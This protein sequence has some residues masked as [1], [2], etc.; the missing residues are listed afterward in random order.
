M[1]PP[2]NNTVTTVRPDNKVYGTEALAIREYRGVPS[3]THEPRSVPAEQRVLNGYQKVPWAVFVPDRFIGF[4][5]KFFLHDRYKIRR[6]LGIRTH[7]Y[8]VLHWPV[9]FAWS[10]KSPCV[11]GELSIHKCRCDFDPT[12]FLLGLNN[13]FGRIRLGNDAIAR[14][15]PS[16]QFIQK[17]LNIEALMCFLDCAAT[18][19]HARTSVRRQPRPLVGAGCA[20]G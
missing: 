11:F 16:I 20:L 5:L 17:H 10:C 6:E 15:V 14:A 4:L 19:G 1:L 8:V 13:R 2:Q 18:S 9:R 7:N 3:A 12:C